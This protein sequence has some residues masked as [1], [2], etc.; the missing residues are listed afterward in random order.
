M[1]PSNYK[2]QNSAPMHKFLPTLHTE[3]A[4]VPERS[5]PRKLQS[6]KHFAS[7]FV[8]I[9]FLATTSIYSFPCPPSW[10]SQSRFKFLLIIIQ[11]FSLEHNLR[12][13]LSYA[14]CW[15]KNTICHFLT[16]DVLLLL[17]KKQTFR[18]YIH[19]T[20]EIK[21]IKRHTKVC[22]IMLCHFENCFLK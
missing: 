18:S 14:H 15:Y 9:G 2:I 20:Y 22:K 5:L 4:H 16:F 7:R 3:I 21:G 13:W 11:I 10:S 8:A 17:W 12:K 19:T 1:Q 6:S